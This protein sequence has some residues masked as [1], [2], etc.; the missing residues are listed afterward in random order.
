MTFAVPDAVQPDDFMVVANNAT[1][2]ALDFVMANKIAVVDLETLER[3]KAVRTVI[4]ERMKVITETL[5]QP[6]KAA[7]DVH[8]WFCVVEKAALRP[9]ESLDAWERAQIAAFNTAESLR[10]QEREREIAK[11]RRIADETR[12]TAEAAAL[13][14]AGEPMMALAV[15]AEAI[16]APDPVVVLPDAVRAT[17]QK[18]RTSYKWRIT[19]SELIP[20]EFLMVDEV[21]LN[22]YAKA[23][24]ES[25]EVPGIAFY[26]TDDPIR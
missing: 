14:K 26:H 24:K 17:G 16:T 23:M 21:K 8:Q 22:A 1:E 25:A 12:A 3:A 6:K 2:Q 7:Y 15:L 19:H 13:E 11:A 4:G 9:Y 5:A 18:F 10:R 20:R